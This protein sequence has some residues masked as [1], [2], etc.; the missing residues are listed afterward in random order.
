MSNRC[1]DNALLRYVL[2][3]LTKEEAAEGRG[4]LAE[5]SS[6]V[7]YLTTFDNADE[8]PFAEEAVSTAAVDD[9]LARSPD[10]WE[11]LFAGNRDRYATPAAVQALIQACEIA[12]D[13][14]LARAD[15]LSL[16]LTE[17]ADALPVSFASR[18]LQ[19]LAWT[20]RATA[21]LRQG[22]LVDAR[23]AVKTAEER[24]SHIPAADYERALIAFTA[25]DI[26]RELGQ[27][28][29]A[30]RQIRDAA[31]VFRGYKDMRRWASAREM[32]AAVLFRRGDYRAAADL[33]LALLDAGPTDLVVRGRLIANAA[34]SFVRLGEHERALPLFDRAEQIFLELKYDGYVTRILWGKARAIH[35]LGNDETAIAALREVRSEERR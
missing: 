25:A 34:Q 20:R 4:H 5:C 26:L 21:L 31:A 11:R 22:R 3:L 24:A 19:A 33:Y 30:L 35:A 17:S 23:A 28:D 10:R 16:I 8:E 6:C 2:K 1:D 29:D 15:V 14:D 9:L 18:T 7:A 13:R 27:T 32:E 12:L